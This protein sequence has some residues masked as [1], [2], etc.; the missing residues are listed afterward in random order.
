MVVTGEYVYGYYDSQPVDSSKYVISKIP[1]DTL[2]RSPKKETLFLTWHHGLCYEIE[3]IT[4]EYIELTY[5]ANGKT[6]SYRRE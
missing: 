4:E 3:G 1:C 2:Y 6:L 5:T